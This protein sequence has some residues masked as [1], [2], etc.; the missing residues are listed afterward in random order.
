[1]KVSTTDYK[2]CDVVKISGKIDHSTA[3]ELE[4]A[5][6]ELTG[7]GRYKIVLDMSEVEYMSSAGLRVLSSVQHKCKQ[8]N[9]GEVVLALVPENIYDV[10]DMVAFL[11]IF[12]TFDSIVDAAGY[13]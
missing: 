4:K 10:L 9:R 13:F 3:P 2:R 1:M 11:K 8:F 12:K 5:L 6:D 7:A